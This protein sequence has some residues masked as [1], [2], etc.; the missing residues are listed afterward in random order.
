MT[1]L[2]KE[3]FSA[4][5]RV[6]EGFAFQFLGY[7]S[8]DGVSACSPLI[9]VEVAEAFHCFYLKKKTK[10]KLKPHPVNVSLI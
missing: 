4:T 7:A 6:F 2:L 10:Q 1:W 9:V 5:E 3:R 8:T